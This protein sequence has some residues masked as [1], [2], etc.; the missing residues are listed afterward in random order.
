DRLRSRDPRVRRA[1][2]ASIDLLFPRA[3]A[4]RFLRMV[5]KDPDAKTRAT[6]F[7]AMRRLALGDVAVPDTRYKPGKRIRP[8]TL[9]AWNPTG[10]LFGLH[11]RKVKAAGRPKDVAK[12][13]LPALAN[14]KD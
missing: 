5:I 8:R 6:A 4:G 14:P 12:A 11:R 1:A 9:G 3:Q 7:R 10:W 2:V 13:K